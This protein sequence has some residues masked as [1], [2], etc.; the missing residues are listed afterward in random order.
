[1]CLRGA[2]EVP[3]TSMA[4]SGISKEPLRHTQGTYLYRHLWSTNLEASSH[5]LSFT[6]PL[7]AASNNSRCIKSLAQFVTST[8]GFASPCSKASLSC[9]A[10]AAQELTAAP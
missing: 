5:F 4:R 8:G 1:M 2:L 3:G 10:C 9:K 6:A 7:T